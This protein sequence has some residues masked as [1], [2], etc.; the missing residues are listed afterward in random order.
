MGYCS[1]FGASLRNKRMAIGIVLSAPIT[2]N[3]RPI[4][5]R[6]PREI[7]FESN[8]PIPAPIIPRVAAKRPSSGYE[9]EILLFIC[10]IDLLASENIKHTGLKFRK[11]RAPDQPAR[12]RR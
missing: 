9:I 3:G 4:A 6:F 7:R 2:N 12:R 1:I 11:Q 8:K 5:R 10:K